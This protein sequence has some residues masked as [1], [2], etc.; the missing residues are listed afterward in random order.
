[1]LAFLIVV[2]C[3]ATPPEPV[4]APPA[5]Q[6]APVDPI[7]AALARIRADA[8]PCMGPFARVD[9]W[10]TTADGSVHRLYFHG[11]LQSCSHPPSVWYDATGAR[12]E[13]VANEPVTDA[14]RAR[15]DAIWARHTT[16]AEKAETRSLPE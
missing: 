9:V 10:R 12:L 1:M 11:D 8:P 4:E 13:A 7:D 2:G 15:Y 5:A 14:N 16:G 3:H 6:E